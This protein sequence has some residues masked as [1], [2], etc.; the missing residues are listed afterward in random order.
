MIAGLPGRSV[1]V[2]DPRLDG[3][4]HQLHWTDAAM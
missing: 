2:V 4:L 3:V 1:D